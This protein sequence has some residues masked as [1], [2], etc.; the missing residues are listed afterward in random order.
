MLLLLLLLLLGLPAA[1]AAS[2][3]RPGPLGCPRDDHAGEALGEEL[4]GQ[5]RREVRRQIA[6]V[7][8]LVCTGDQPA[9]AA[10][11]SA[12]QSTSKVCMLPVLLPDMM[13]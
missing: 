1:A 5:Q 3:A 2:A 10:T 6:A 13:Q 8:L 11:T 7:G 4:V 9:T 12:K